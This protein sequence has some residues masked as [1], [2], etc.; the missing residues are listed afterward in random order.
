M[1]RRCKNM[2]DEDM[3]Q[4][5]SLS[6]GKSPGEV[7]QELLQGLSENADAKQSVQNY[8]KAIAYLENV[9]RPVK[10]V[11]VSTEEDELTEHTR[12]YGKSG[13]PEDYLDDFASFIQSNINEIASLNIVCTKPKEL[14]R[15]SLK[16]AMLHGIDSAITRGDTLSDTGKGMKDYDLVLTNPPFGTKKGGERASR[17]DFTYLT[18]HKQL[19]FLQHIYRSLKRGGRA[20]VVLPDNV[21]FADGDGVRIRVD[22][23]MSRFDTHRQKM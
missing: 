12:G 7:I 18:S 20:A 14:T 19:N 9:K 23:M 2:T 22:L 6:G 11:V 16:D 15:K 5:K 8:G 10:L 13:R 4:F 3:D 17:D 21:L 1:Q